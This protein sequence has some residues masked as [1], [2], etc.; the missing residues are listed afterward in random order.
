[1]APN[2]RYGFRV[3]QTLNE[4]KIWYPVNT[5][6]GWGLLAIGMAEIGVATALYFVPGIGVDVYASM[7]GIVVVVGVIVGL[8][9]SFRRLHQLTKGYEAE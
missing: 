2:P 7:V 6:S 8:V 1:V 9:Q 3:P 5:Y 4:P